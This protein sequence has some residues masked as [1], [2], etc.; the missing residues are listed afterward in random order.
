MVQGEPDG[1]VMATLGAVLLLFIYGRLR[2][3]RRGNAGVTMEMA[4]AEI[5]DHFVRTDGSKLRRPAPDGEGP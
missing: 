1:F 5:R 2:S 4:V 3:E